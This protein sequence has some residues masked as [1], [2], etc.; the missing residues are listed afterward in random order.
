MDGWYRGQ[1][2]FGVLMLRG[3]QYCVRW[4]LL[5]YPAAVHHRH[6]MGKAADYADV[7][8]NEKVGQSQFFLQACQQGQ[9]ARLDRL[10]PARWWVRH[11]PVVSA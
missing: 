11:R 9:D 5:Y 8:G 7:M 4:P 1:Q 2:G 6:F 3:G 10:R